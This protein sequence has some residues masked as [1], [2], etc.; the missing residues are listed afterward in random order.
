MMH[1][2]STVRTLEELLAVAVPGSVNQ[3]RLQRLSLG[4]A[5]QAAWAEAERWCPELPPDLV[6]Q[7]RQRAIDV[8]QSG[9]E[10]DDH[11]DN[12]QR[13]WDRW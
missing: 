8:M 6:A 3:E 2:Q 1:V 7:R 11:R 4:R 13:G 9:N 10:S 5:N 12:Y